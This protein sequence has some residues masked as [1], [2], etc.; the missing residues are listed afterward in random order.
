VP[1]RSV[2]Y[3]APFLF[4][5]FFKN[6]NL[7]LLSIVIIIGSTELKLHESSPQVPNRIYEYDKICTNYLILLYYNIVTKYL[8]IIYIGG[9]Y[10]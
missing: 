7:Y 9:Y 4:Y 1:L 3:E 5:F 6:L 2:N 10:L 8:Q